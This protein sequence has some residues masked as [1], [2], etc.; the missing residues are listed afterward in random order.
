H[1]LLAMTRIFEGAPDAAV[2]D[3]RAVLADTQDQFARALALDALALA[4]NLRGRFVEAAELIAASAR[5]VEAI[6]S[7]AAYDSCPHLILGVQLARLD[8]L[9]EAADAVQRGRRASEALGMIDTLAP[10]Y[11]R[12]A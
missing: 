8:R 9:D 4:A 6:G 5:T 7:R 12:L 10:V 2:H 1:G 11:Y 3:A